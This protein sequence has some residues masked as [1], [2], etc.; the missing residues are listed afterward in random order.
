MSR[1]LLSDEELRQIEQQ[2]PDTTQVATLVH[3]HGPDSVAMQVGP[4]NRLPNAAVCLHDALQMVQEA[5]H[6]LHEAMAHR[7]YY[8]APQNEPAVVWFGRFYCADVA[9]RLYAAGE[10]Y[11]NAVIEM[12]DI[13]EASLSPYKAGVTSRQAVVGRF[14]QE[15]MPTDGASMAVKSLVSEADWTA[16]IAYRN[17]WVHEQAPTMSELGIVWRRGRAR[18]REVSS[19]MGEAHVLHVG[20]GDAPEGTVDDLIAQVSHAMHLFVDAFHRLVEE[21]VL[22]VDSARNQT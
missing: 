13:A 9:L 17:A 16:T 8:R 4:M 18:W 14:L 20:G 10:H 3:E 7:T 22:L 1:G 2:L 15:K 6:A 21:Y 19:T 12:L 5:R 11:A